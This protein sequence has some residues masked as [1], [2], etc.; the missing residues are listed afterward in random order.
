MAAAHPPPRQFDDHIAA[1]DLP[2]PVASRA[3]IPVDLALT[4]RRPG[5]QHNLMPLSGQ[6]PS[7]DGADLTSPTGMTTFTHRSSAGPLGV[8]A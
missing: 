7:E 5:E 1:I 3:A 8:A 6:R 2:G 4:H